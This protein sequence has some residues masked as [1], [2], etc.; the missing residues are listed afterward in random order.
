MSVTTT[1]YYKYYTMKPFKKYLNESS[2]SRLWK[3]N[4]EHDAGA[5]T[6]FRKGSECGTG[7][8][9][10]KKENTQRNTG[11]ENTANMINV[12]NYGNFEIK[13]I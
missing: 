10:S 4:E 13:E 5:L 6:A 3:H 11:N 2:L 12:E 1:V 7:E 8:T 9:Y